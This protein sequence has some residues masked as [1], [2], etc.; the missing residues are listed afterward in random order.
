LILA[1]LVVI[2]IWLQIYNKFW[3]WQIFKIY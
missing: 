3:N 1:L 2:H